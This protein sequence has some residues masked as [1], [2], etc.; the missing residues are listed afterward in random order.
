[1]FYAT[2]PLKETVGGGFFFHFSMYVFSFI[3]SQLSWTRYV[4]TA[5]VQSFNT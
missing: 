3:L 2:G 5:H 1:M 4:C